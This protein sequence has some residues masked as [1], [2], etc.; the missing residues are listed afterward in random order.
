MIP[1][2][3]SLFIHCSV[4]MEK[5][6]HDARLIKTAVCAD[7]NLSQDKQKP[8]RIDLLKLDHVFFSQLINL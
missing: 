6:Q 3:V 5:I 8:G 1:S 2:D 7:A 4:I